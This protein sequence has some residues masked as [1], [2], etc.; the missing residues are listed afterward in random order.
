MRLTFPGHSL[1]PREVGGETQALRT[2]SLELKPGRLICQ[3]G[4]YSFSFLMQSGN[5]VARSGLGP[6]ACILYQPRPSPTEML[7][8]QSHLGNSSI[9]V[10][11][12][13][14]SGLCQVDN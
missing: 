8:G 10:F 3:L 7:K 11:L 12:S 2:G 13:D 14:D 4:S 5:A 9:E 1:S 6:P